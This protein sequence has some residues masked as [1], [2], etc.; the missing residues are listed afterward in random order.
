[1]K[2]L[3]PA[4][5]GIVA[6]V[7]FV[8]FSLATPPPARDKV[9]K[10]PGRFK[11]LSQFNGEAVLDKETRL[12]K[13]QSPNTQTRTWSAALD[14]CYGKIIGGPKGWRPPTIEELASLLGQRKNSH[15]LHPSSNAR[16]SVYW[17][18]ATVAGNS[19]NAWVVVLVNGNVANGAKTDSLFVWCARG[20]DGRN[21][22]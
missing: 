18:A 21:G 1:M 8:P 13:E 14:H 9:I 19:S 22:H 12:I 4:L 15:A 2:S 10:S 3:C 16:P 6:F 17:S 7:G 5:I 11:P 20:G